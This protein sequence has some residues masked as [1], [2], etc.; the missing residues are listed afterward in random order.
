MNTPDYETGTQFLARVAAHRNQLLADVAYFLAVPPPAR[1]PTLKSR[2]LLY[3]AM[4]I[5]A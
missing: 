3:L 4:S 1:M 5:P 2:T